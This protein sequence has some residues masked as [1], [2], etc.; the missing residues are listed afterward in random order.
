[1]NSEKI[2]NKPRTLINLI[3]IPSLLS[4][5]YFGDLI[6]TSFIYIVIFLCTKELYNICKRKE[7]SLN[8]MWLYTIYILMYISHYINFSLIRIKE[9]AICLFFLLFISQLIKN[10]KKSLSSTAITL[11]A[12][13][14]IGLFLDCAIYLRNIPNGLNFIYCIFLSVWVCDSAAY[15]F[16]SKFG[17]LKILPHISPNKTWVGTLSGLL[18]STIFVYVLVSLDFITLNTYVFSIKDIMIIGIIIGVIGQLGDFFESMIKREFKIKDSGTLLQG[19]GGVLDRF[20]SLLFVFPA[21]YLYIQ[22]IL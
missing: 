4:I 5:I 15:I 14:W 16:G 11:F 18:F 3:G 7:Y 9:V 19:H 20:D 21:F 8:I 17:K 22:Y 12:F 10:D 2:H 6:F 1:M 13:V